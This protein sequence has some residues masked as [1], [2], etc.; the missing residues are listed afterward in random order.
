MDQITGN[1][2]S[3]DEGTSDWKFAHQR[4]SQMLIERVEPFGSLTPIMKLDA[5]GTRYQ[6]PPVPSANRKALRA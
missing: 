2:R 1:P 4:L 6:W 5:A 3:H